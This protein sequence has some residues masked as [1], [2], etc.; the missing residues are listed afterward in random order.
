M[1]SNI[2]T[3]LYN[4]VLDSY[5][6]ILCNIEYEYIRGQDQE[7]TNYWEFSS[8]GIAPEIILRCVQFQYTSSKDLGHWLMNQLEWKEYLNSIAVY[9]VQKELQNEESELYLTLIANAQG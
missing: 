2:H 4:L 1:V 9:H 3:Y 6:I 5:P 7:F 8:P